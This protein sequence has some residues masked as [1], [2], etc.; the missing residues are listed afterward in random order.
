[1]SRFPDLSFQK[2]K[3]S[4]VVAERKTSLNL[5]DAFWLSLKEIAAQEGTPVSQLVNRINTDRK[6]TCPRHSGCMYWT[7]I[8]D[9][10]TRL[11]L[12]MLLTM[13]LMTAALSLSACGWQGPKGDKGD[14]GEKGAKGDKGDQ[15]A[16]GPP[17]K[18]SAFVSVRVVRG[19]CRANPAS[20]TVACEAG[21]EF[22]SVTCIGGPTG[23]QVRDGAPMAQC[24]PN[25]GPIIAVC[26]K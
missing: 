20:C 6:P 10:P 25:N 11:L 9:W 14:P 23:F 3:P 21:E 2:S 13:L 19:T 4:V 12:R 15:G 8:V 17:G 26:G 5:E 16:S 22:V 7:T 24:R 18:D 1:M